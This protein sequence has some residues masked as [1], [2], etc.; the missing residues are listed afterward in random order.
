MWQYWKAF[1]ILE[2]LY[3]IQWSITVFGQLSHT[4]STRQ[5]FYQTENYVAEYVVWSR[6]AD[7]YFTNSVFAVLNITPNQ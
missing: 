5:N 1:W 2:W 3:I 6:M 7:I 4:K